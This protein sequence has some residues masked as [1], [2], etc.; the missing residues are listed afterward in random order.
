MDYTQKLTHISLCTGYGGIDLGLRDALRN[1]RTITYVEIEAFA[2][3]NLVSKIEA[4]LLDPAPI[5]SDLKSFPWR[6]FAGRVDILSG[7]FPCQPFS[8]AGRNNADTDPRHLWPSIRNGIIELRKP[9]IIFFENV[10]GIISSTLKSEGWA[11]PKGTPVLLHILR[12]M[13]RMGYTAEAGVFSA[14]EVGAPH[15]RKRVF[16]MGVRS[17]LSKAKQDIVN[18]ILN[19]G[20][21]SRKYGKSS[22]GRRQPIEQTLLD[23][24]RESSTAYPAPRGADVGHATRQQDTRREFRNPRS[25]GVP[26]WENVFFRSTHAGFTAYP[27]PR[28]ADQYEWEPPRVTVGNTQH[29]GYTASKIRGSDDTTFTEW[30]AQGKNSIWEPKRTSSLEHLLSS[31][32]TL[33]NSNS[34]YK[35]P[36]RRLG[37]LSTK[38][39]EGETNEFAWAST[40]NLSRIKMVEAFFPCTPYFWSRREQQFEWKSSRITSP[41]NAEHTQF[42]NFMVDDSCSERF[43]RS[44]NALRNGSSERWEITSRHDASTSACHRRAQRQTQSS[45]GR[46]INGSPYRMDYAELCRSSDS[47]VDELRLLGNGV[48]PAVAARAFTNLWTIIASESRY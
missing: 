18:R 47:R 44:H 39:R 41:S 42:E 27:A 11:D 5:F 48:V 26:T 20:N 38:N 43:K 25:S 22:L 16:I 4:G 6:K 28:G 19:V 8:S 14:A 3:E 24:D 21:T 31:A 23:A 12:E 45:V 9:P 32:F 37:V 7:G 17:D 29:N 15:Q 46:S 34:G 33:G 30:Q 1:V 13:E 2:V 40:A 36:R 10:E 35:R